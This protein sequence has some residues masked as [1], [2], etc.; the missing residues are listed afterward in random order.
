M[1]VQ[2]SR[3]ERS[4]CADWF[5]K[6]TRMHMGQQ[7]E[8]VASTAAPKAGTKAGKANYPS[9]GRT[10]SHEAAIKVQGPDSPGF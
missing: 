7:H 6:E 4:A 2:A 8:Q 10:W 9:E 3:E 1:H 5:M